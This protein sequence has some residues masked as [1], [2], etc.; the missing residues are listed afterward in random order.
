LASSIA[1]PRRLRPKRRSRRKRA[2]CFGVNIADR[3]IV[4]R[5]SPVN[6]FL[7]PR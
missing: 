3:N 5:T 4:L 2:T 7:L 1:R 6:H